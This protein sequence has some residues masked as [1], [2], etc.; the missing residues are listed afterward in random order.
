MDE[1]TRRIAAFAEAQKFDTLPP[2]I[3]DATR[4]RLVDTL[5]CVVG[6]RDSEAAQIGL[7]LTD[8]AVPKSF[9]GRVIGYR[10]RN[11]AET[12]AFVNSAM[13][14]YLDYN[15]TGPGSHPS[16]C[17]GAL[18]AIAEAAGASGGEL[19]AAT[20]VAYEIIFRLA[21]GTKFRQRGWDQGFGAA[22]AT[23]AGAAQLLRLP[24]EQIAHAVSIAAVANVPLRAS[25]AGNLSYWK[26]AATPFA[27]KNGL[28][29]ALLAAKGMTGPEKPFEGRFGLWEQI[30]GPFEID[31]F[32][33]E[34]GEFMLPRWS[35]FKYWPV[36]YNAQ[37]GVWAA[38]QLREK[39]PVE[40]LARV[41]ISTYHQAWHE[42]GSEEAKWDPKTRETADHSL[43]YIFARTLVDGAISVAS[44]EEAAFGD[45]GIRPLMRKISVKADETFSSQFP[46]IVPIRVE[47]TTLSGDVHR[48]EMANPKGHDL[49]PMDAADVT[50]KFMRLV[51]PA[52]GQAG[53]EAAAAA[54]WK[55]DAAPSLTAAFD[56]LEPARH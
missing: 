4:L 40:Q 11:T 15:D 24:L 26:S 41:E 53:A 14:R 23:A 17:I 56:L 20:V 22:I 10:D 1:L 34:G 38:R 2:A 47:A 33:S 28:A 35:R 29:A 8:G 54:W 30:T 19:I 16:D 48:I 37:I 50:E 12:A 43:P 46:A 5:A 21:F 32:P 36:E 18:F 6:G 3:V 55:I 39:I 9:P 25:R 45:P 13:G 52:L 7:A 44:F 31:A 49:N 51:V 42:I 27:V